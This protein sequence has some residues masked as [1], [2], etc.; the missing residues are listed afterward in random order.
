M[1]FG[2]ADAEPPGFSQTFR[3]LFTAKI[4]VDSISWPD[5]FLYIYVFIIFTAW[6]KWMYLSCHSM[7]ILHHINFR[8]FYHHP[9]EKAPTWKLLT[10]LKKGRCVDAFPAVQNYMTYINIMLSLALP[11]KQRSLYHPCFFLNVV[12]NI[13]LLNQIA[14]NIISMI[15]VTSDNITWNVWFRY[16]ASLEYLHIGFMA[17]DQSFGVF[18][19][20]F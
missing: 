14:D 12:W 10:H 18:F 2:N 20:F 5:I 11:I 1:I 7:G 3:D 8:V 19:L 6:Y 16:R 13:I 4:N 17:N 9:K 15:C